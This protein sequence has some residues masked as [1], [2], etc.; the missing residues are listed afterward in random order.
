MGLKKMKVRIVGVAPLLLQSPQALDPENAL[1]KQLK[2]LT[3]VKG[4]T[5]DVYKEIARIEWYVG[6]YV[7][8]QKHIV[9]PAN[10]LEACLCSGAKKSKEGK[11]FLSAVF[12]EDDALLDFPGKKK[13]LKVLC[14][15]PQ[16]RLTVP[17]RV[18]QARVM[19][20]RPCFRKW[21][22]DF[23]VTY[24]SDVVDRT[25][26]D[27]ALRLGGQLCGIGTWR[28]KFGRFDVV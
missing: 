17:V 7:N 12:V 13:P 5:L 23:E 26:V 15:D 2:E 14:A 11:Q 25:K 16:F 4:K 28:P 22:V 21:A 6:L 18:Q 1:G 19:R 8:A 27:R 3:S 20:T 9:V 24:N 10:M